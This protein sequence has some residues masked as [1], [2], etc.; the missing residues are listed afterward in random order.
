MFDRLKIFTID[1]WLKELYICV[2][3]KK[4]C[5]KFPTCNFE[6]QKLTDCICILV[7]LI[8]LFLDD[9]KFNACFKRQFF[10]SYCELLND[11]QKYT[12]LMILEALFKTNEILDDLK[13]NL[14]K[15]NFNILDNKHKCDELI[16]EFKNSIFVPIQNCKLQWY[17]SK[18][19]SKYDC[20]LLVTKLGQY[21][22][23][24][25]KIGEKK[26]IVFGISDQTKCSYHICIYN[27][28]NLSSGE[29]KDWDLFDFSKY[30]NSIPVSPGTILNFQ[31]FLLCLEMMLLKRKCQ[32]SLRK[33]FRIFEL[34]NIKI[35]LKSI[36]V[37][38]WPF[39][40]EIFYSYLSF[41]VIFYFI[42]TKPNRILK[43]KFLNLNNK[44]LKWSWSFLLNNSNLN[45]VGNF[46]LYLPSYIICEDRF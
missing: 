21:K 28:I 4:S 17:K 35:K 16:W 37:L 1:R 23:C 15:Y 8:D 30:T 11:K 31:D 14:L 34:I 43:N 38:N 42:Y 20:K 6:N 22:R 41:Y 7:Y 29:V 27:D 2:L 5:T 12:L 36:G 24:K 46:S 3:S 45:D 25:S 9:K 26:M 33:K 32:T 13:N 18:Y 44:I 40:L 39:S 10:S 19:I